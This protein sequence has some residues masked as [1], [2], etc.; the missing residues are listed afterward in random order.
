MRRIQILL[1]AVAI[2]AI[3]A[4]VTAQQSA[5][6]KADL[7]TDQFRG[8]FSGKTD[9]VRST[10]DGD[11]QTLLDRFRLWNKCGPMSLHVVDPLPDAL[12]IGLTKKQVERNIR[13]RLRA[14]RLYS[15]DA[16]V[17]LDVD[18]YVHSTAFPI[19]VRFQKPVIEPL[20]QNAA[21]A[22]TW[23]RGGSAGTYGEGG[24][25]YVLSAVARHIDR[26]IDEYYRVNEDACSRR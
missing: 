2:V 3:A 23:Y 26:F 24:G 16:P 19:F 14:A 12:R 11:P 8:Q 22:A 10:A 20:S 15:E 21:L 17:R 6:E 13:S 7:F 4:P 25:G 18:A 5:Q 9:M 1:C